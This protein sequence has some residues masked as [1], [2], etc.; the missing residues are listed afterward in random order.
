VFSGHLPMVLGARHHR[1]LVTM[2]LIGTARVVGAAWSLEVWP[3]R[4]IQQV[5][6]LL[7]TR[8][9]KR[10]IASINFL[11]VGPPLLKTSVPCCSV[12]R[13]SN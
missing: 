8:W 3:I 11:A 6:D 13:M 9:T 4:A 7:A 12:R 5:L 1:V 2:V 10:A